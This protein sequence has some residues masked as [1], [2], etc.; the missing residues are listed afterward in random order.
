MFS[1]FYCLLPHQGFHCRFVVYMSTSHFRPN[2][3]FIIKYLNIMFLVCNLYFYVTKSW[4]IN[5]KE[6][7]NETHKAVFYIYLFTDNLYHNLHY[8]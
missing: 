6:Q 7:I 2:P 8:H 1:F 4:H 3:D 5:R